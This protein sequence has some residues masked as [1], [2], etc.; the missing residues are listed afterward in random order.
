MRKDPYKLFVKQVL[1]MKREFKNY[2]SVLLLF[3]LGGRVMA[4]NAT[5][6]H[7]V[8]PA[9]ASVS[10]EF[11]GSGTLVP[12]VA[13]NGLNSAHPF[14]SPT[15]FLLIYNTAKAGTAPYDVSP[16]YY[17]WTG[18]Q[19]V[20]MAYSN[21]AVK[22]IDRGDKATIKEDI[23]VGPQNDYT[24]AKPALPE[25]LSEE[26]FHYADFLHSKDA[27][28]EFSNEK[29][30]VNSK[31][32]VAIGTSEFNSTYPEKFLVDVGTNGSINAISARGNNDHYVQMN[33]QNSSTSTTASTDIVATNNAGSE[34][35]NYVDLGINSSTNSTS[36]TLGGASTAYLFSTGNDFVIGNGSPS[37]TLTLFATNAAGQTSERIRLNEHG[38]TVSHPIKMVDGDYTCTIDD[39][40]VLVKNSSAV[41]VQLPPAA[42]V[43]GRCFSIKKISAS[44]GGRKVSIRPQQNEL[45]DSSRSADISL[46]NQVY[47]VQSDGTSWWII[48]K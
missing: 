44:N 15:E 11:E 4:Q 18:K 29:M 41:T 13:L 40:T 26:N 8:S 21:V 37:K 14:T 16:G 12:Q 7:S 20:R 42:S 1:P 23:F 34:T 39:Y 30:H 45:I 47:V 17:S 2:L 5:Q 3:A 22:T 10:S 32:D 24:G 36:G 27:F 6:S 33:I 31:G 25:F 35:V 43:A 9:M 28:K 19:W 46:A 48:S 38:A